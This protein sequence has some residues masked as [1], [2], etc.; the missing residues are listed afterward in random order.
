MTAM[1]AIATE[2]VEMDH[3]HAAASDVIARV[4]GAEAGFVTACCASAA[5]GTNGDDARSAHADGLFQ[6]R[7]RPHSIR[8]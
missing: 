8:R 4:T 3:L 7:H 2:F 1:A 5:D 6:R